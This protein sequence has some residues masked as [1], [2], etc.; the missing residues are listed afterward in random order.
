MGP[1]LV[2]SSLTSC[3][4]PAGEVLLEDAATSARAVDM[5]LVGEQTQVLAALIVEATR[6]EFTW[7]RERGGR[8]RELPARHRW[9]ATPTPL[10]SLSFQAL[11]VA[12]TRWRYGEFG[13][14]E[15]E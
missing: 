4:T 9:N 11:A 1:L 5:A 8:L 3:L 14:P 7:G 6:G 13:E 15:A 12:G 2:P 10:A